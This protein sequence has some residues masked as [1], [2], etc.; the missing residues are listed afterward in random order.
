MFDAGLGR[1]KMHEIREAVAEAYEMSPRDLLV[2]SHK[3]HY[4]RPRQVAITLC[5]E[6]TAQS[7]PAIARSFGNLD[8]STCIFAHRMT[9]KRLAEDPKLA[10]RYGA[11]KAKLSA[12]I[13]ERQPPAAVLLPMLKPVRFSATMTWGIAA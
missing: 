9:L 10:E 7:Y 12:R 8:H 5:R 13:L 11:I 4:A 2:R 1:V 3:W 6:L